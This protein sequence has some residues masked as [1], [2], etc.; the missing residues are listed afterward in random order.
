MRKSDTAHAGGLATCQLGGGATTTLTAIAPRSPTALIATLHFSGPIFS[1]CVA[2][3]HLRCCVA[4][5]A[6]RT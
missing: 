3:V 5:F 1:G 2:S 6:F 4:G